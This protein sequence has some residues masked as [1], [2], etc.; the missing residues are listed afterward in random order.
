MR[1]YL[2]DNGY[3]T[4]ENGG[5]VEVLPASNG[6][7]FTL[8]V[9]KDIDG[10]WVPEPWVAKHIKET[11]SRILLD[12]RTLWPNGDF[13]TA[14]IIVRTD[15]LRANPDVIEKLIEAHID[16]TNWINENPDEA[17]EMFNSELVRLTG[18][19]IPEDE[20]NDAISRLRLTY[21]P[22]KVSLVGSADAAYEVGFF[23]EEP[24]LSGIY[25]LTILNKV[26]RERGLTEIS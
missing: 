25:D 23:K 5:N 10:A 1:K 13:V 19:S 3:Q 15:Y 18:K 16:E 9:K 7:I 8:L 21:D 14:H 24:N 6:D 26:L 17:R 4:K 22:V 20:F 2:L 11:N 12:E